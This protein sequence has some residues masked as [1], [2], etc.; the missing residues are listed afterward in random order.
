[1]NKREKHVIDKV[2]PGCQTV[3]PAFV[4]RTDK[5]CA[6]WQFS[7]CGQCW[8]VKDDCPGQTSAL[9][10]PDVHEVLSDDMQPSEI[11]V[12]TDRVLKADPDAVDV[13]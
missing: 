1:M 5:G 10:S 8:T 2:C 9:W 7:D 11:Q 3:Q 6:E 12:T 4:T 13:K